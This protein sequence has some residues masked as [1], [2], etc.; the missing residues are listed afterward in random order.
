MVLRPRSK[1]RHSYDGGDFV[2][3]SRPERA[4]CMYKYVVK[5]FPIGPPDESADQG[6]GLKDGGI[7]IAN[8]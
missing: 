5:Q 1:G 3:A 2:E 7:G 4:G 8:I 6:T